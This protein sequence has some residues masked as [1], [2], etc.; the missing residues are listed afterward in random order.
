METKQLS[1]NVTNDTDEIDLLDLI[2]VLWK[3]KWLIVSVSALAAIGSVVFALI[4]IKLPPEKSPLPNLYKPQAIILVNDSSSGGG[5]QSALASSGLGG[6]AGIAGVSGGGGYGELAVKLLSTNTIIDAVVEEFDIIDKYEITEQ[7]KGSSRKLV[8]SKASFNFDAE[9]STLSIS[10]EEPDPVFATDVVNF[11]VALLERRFANIGGNRNIRERNLLEVKL[12]EVDAEILRLESEL[13]EFQRKH[14]TLSPE[15][16]ATEQVTILG[17]M[18][19]RLINKEIEIETYSEF[20]SDN[21]PF[22]RRL[23][24]ERNQLERS[25]AEMEKRYYGG[26]SD[27]GDSDIPALAVEYARLERDIR[28][29]ARIYEVLTQQYELAKLSIEGEDP[30][31]QV[32][33]LAD[34]PDIKSGPSRSIIVIVVTMAGF[35]VSVLLAFVLNAWKN[36]RNDP[37]RMA[38]LTGRAG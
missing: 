16:L 24:S 35:F 9:T 4:S 14:G 37:E 3:H 13:Q 7:V 8:K 10:F 19:A 34:V 12:A 31:F 38:K 29:Q 32:L 26:T 23:Q 30:I 33:E 15:V 1:D 18:R 25:I 17:E 11:F 21:D 36:I 5:L 27:S 6:L 22:L 20:A 28:V 2:G